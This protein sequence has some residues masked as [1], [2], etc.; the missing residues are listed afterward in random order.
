M[1]ACADLALT[2]TGRLR[3]DE[4][5]VLGGHGFMAVPYLPT[6]VR[7]GAEALQQELTIG[8]AAVAA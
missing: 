2:M 1:K 6:D 3:V 4:T 7:A 8:L 5:S